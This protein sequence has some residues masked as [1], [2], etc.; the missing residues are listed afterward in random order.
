MEN[1]KLLIILVEVDEGTK[2]PFKAHNEILSLFG[3]VGQSEQLCACDEP[4]INDMRWA[5]DN[6]G[7]D[8]DNR[9]RGA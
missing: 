3:V 2:T 4:E 7:K 5:C 8:F 1:S 6:C 9:Y